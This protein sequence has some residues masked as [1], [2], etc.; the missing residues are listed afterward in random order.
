[1]LPRQSWQSNIKFMGYGY[2]SLWPQVMLVRSRIAGRYRPPF[3]PWLFF[4][5]TQGAPLSGLSFRPRAV[6]VNQMP[7]PRFTAKHDKRKHFLSRE[8]ESISVAALRRSGA[9]ER[10]LNRLTHGR[11]NRLARACLPPVLAFCSRAGTEL[12]SSSLARNQ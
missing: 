9:K 5:D 7:T 2:V 4:G 12:G 6:I 1:M 8:I 3:R 11:R 10:L